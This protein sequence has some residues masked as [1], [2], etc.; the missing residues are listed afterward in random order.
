MTLAG[1][2]IF[3]FRVKRK[4]L[5]RPVKT[6]LYPF[7]PL[8]FITISIAFV[9]S[10]LI[11]RP[12]QALWGLGVLILGVPVYYFFNRINLGKKSLNE[13]GEY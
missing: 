3:I 12:E 4:N 11:E 1:I 2:S 8:V 7:I 9:I 13:E 10:T 6:P 5:S